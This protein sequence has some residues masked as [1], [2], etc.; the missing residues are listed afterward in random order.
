MQNDENQWIPPDMRFKIN[1]GDWEWVNLEQQWEVVDQC[2]HT[3][4]NCLYISQNETYVCKHHVTVNACAHRVARFY[5][6][7]YKEF[8]YNTDSQ[9]QLKQKIKSKYYMCLN[10]A[11]R[12]HRVY[13]LNELSRLNLIEK[14]FVSFQLH[15]H[16]DKYHITDPPENFDLWND[17]ELFMS[18]PGYE[19]TSVFSKHYPYDFESDF[20]EKSPHIV[21][22]NITMGGERDYDEIKLPSL[23]LINDS[24]FQI[25]TETWFSVTQGGKRS[26]AL[27]IFEK[28]YKTLMCHPL[29]ILGRPG[30][31]KK[32]KEQGF[33]TFPELFDESY[34][35]IEDDYERFTQVVSEIN[36][37]CKLDIN[38][39]HEIYSTKLLPKVVYNQKHL[40]DKFYDNEMMKT[41][42]EQIAD[43]ND[44]PSKY[45]EDR[46]GFIDKNSWFC[47][48]N[49]DDYRLYKLALGETNDTEEIEGH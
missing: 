28:T 23:E 3:E 27:T 44:L 18:E 45:H 38:E 17:K 37:V 4:D 11:T 5:K 30:I 25:V 2:G 24:Y 36:R 10:S 6:H 1:Y 15:K 16:R 20:F 19:E 31:L 29:I 21:D 49:T 13:L 39:L 42:F 33:K 32:L 34:D 47:G 46:G 43:L 41:I 35:E 26:N 7:L 14:G 9:N 22:R 12:P 8:P 40:Y 48:G